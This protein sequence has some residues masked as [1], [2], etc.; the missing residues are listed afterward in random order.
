MLLVCFTVC[1]SYNSDR[2]KMRYV[3]L[4]IK[5]LL[6]CIVLYCIVKCAKIC[7]VLQP[8]SHSER[9]DLKTEQKIQKSKTIAY[10]ADVC[11]LICRRPLACS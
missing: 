1:R 6:Y 3:I 5:R 8:H 7:S 9:C 4:C 2:I 10:S 11:A